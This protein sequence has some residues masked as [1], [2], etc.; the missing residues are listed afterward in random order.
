MDK[1]R[2]NELRREQRSI[3]DEFVKELGADAGH[4]MELHRARSDAKP[5][6]VRVYCL[7]LVKG[8]R[9]YRV[10]VWRRAGV[11]RPSPDGI[12][13]ARQVLRSVRLPE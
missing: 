8:E 6:P 13:L 1:K 3:G 7:L 2:D 4:A 11:R 10:E 5:F 12:E 9:T